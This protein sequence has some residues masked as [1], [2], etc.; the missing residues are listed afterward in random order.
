MDPRNGTFT[1]ITPPCWTLGRPG[2]HSVQRRR[3]DG[4]VLDR[5]GL[6]PSRYFLTK[7]GRLI[8][9]S[10]VGVLDIPPED[11]LRKDRLRPGKML[12]VDTVK[13]ELVDDDKLKAAYASRQPYGEWLDRNLIRM[14]DLKVPNQKVPSHSKEDLIRLQKA[15]GYR[16]EDVSNIM[17]PMAKN[18]SEPSGAMGSDTPLAVLSHTHPP[19]FE[20]FKQM[21]A[22]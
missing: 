6:R 21:F 4:R 22:R 16:Y 1:N 10:E 2:L 13:G 19:L 14:E 7:D 20:Y 5:N 17:I 18:G 11:V 8:L 15:F 12:L 3:C 9:S